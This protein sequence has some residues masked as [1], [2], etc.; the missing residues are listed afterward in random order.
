[1]PVL[2]VQQGHCF[3][4]TGFTGTTGEQ[5]YAVRVAN[6]CVRLLDGQ[7]GWEVRKTLADENNY[8]GD[9][10]VAIHCDGSVKPSAHGAS[11]GYR[12][13][14]GQALAHAWKR[15]Y[16]ARGWKNGFRVDNYTD[17]LAGYYGVRNAVGK[18]N[19]RAFIA[20]CGFRTNG[21][22]RALLDGPGGPERVALAL[23]E[24]LGIPVPGFQ[25]PQRKAED[26]S[27]RLVRGNSNQQVPGKTF[28]FGDLRFYVEQDPRLPKKA[29]RWYTRDTPA[30]RILEKSQGGVDVVEQ[31][32]LDA[33]P[34]G[35]G[36]EIPP[37]VLG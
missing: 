25:P 3:R 26:M 31:K 7:A 34:F 15:A 5:E 28:R 12:T 9:A 21:D 8:R 19:R 33:I 14:E 10:F 22:D 17:A 6:A 23:G 2:V 4:K 32:D 11:V 37:D 20:E 30:Q 18:G 35:P 1:M 27:L 24:A 29:Q 16:Q 13:P 36:G